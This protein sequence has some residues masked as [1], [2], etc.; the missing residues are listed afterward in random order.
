ME[1]LNNKQ[2]NNYLSKSKVNYTYINSGVPVIIFN[3]GAS[4]K[5]DKDLR[6]LLVERS[7]SFCMW[8]F[9]FDYLT[10]F[11]LEFTED[12]SKYL[13]AGMKGGTNMALVG[14]TLT[15]IGKGTEMYQKNKLNNLLS[16]SIKD[17][18]FEL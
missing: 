3:Y 10:E 18:N 1:N 2:S 14:G 16:T 9:K 6:I 17:P 15:G 7:T 4:P 12:L 5:R 8:Q 11:E 13:G